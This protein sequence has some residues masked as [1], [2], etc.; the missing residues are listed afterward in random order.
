MVVIL[1]FRSSI[2]APKNMEYEF[3]LDVIPLLLFSSS[4]SKWSFNARI[5]PSYSSSAR[6]FNNQHAPLP[7]TTVRVARDMMITVDKSIICRFDV[8]S[9]KCYICIGKCNHLLYAN[10]LSF[11]WIFLL[12]ETKSPDS[13]RPMVVAGKMFDSLLSLVRTPPPPFLP[14]HSWKVKIK[15][16]NAFWQG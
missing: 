13:I 7:W 5:L 3:Y 2:A 8:M 6:T 16:S 12:V 10:V 9:K 11:K 15:N 4:K 1:M 14:F